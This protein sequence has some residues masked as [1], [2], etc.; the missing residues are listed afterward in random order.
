M[1]RKRSARVIDLSSSGGS[2]SD[3]FEDVQCAQ[4]FQ[5][6]DSIEVGSDSDAFSDVS[7]I[8]I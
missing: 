3:G 1:R 7:F 4:R 8:L 5:D 6:Y 2:E